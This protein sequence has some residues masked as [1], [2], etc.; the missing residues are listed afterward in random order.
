MVES[1]YKR[2]KTTLNPI[3]D[4]TDRDVWDFI[5]AE[6]IPY[7]ELYNDGFHRL[8]C[9]GC[10]MAAKHGR[11]VEFAKWPKYKLA[12]LKAFDRMLAERQKRG[13]RR[14]EMFST[15]QSV[16][17]WWMKYDIL[18]GQMEMELEEDT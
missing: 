18:P 15:A 4:W 8:G 1:C 6:S 14:D 2:H 12:Y 10:P 7:C 17:N 13:K 3:I 11:E 5:H 16:F 9:V